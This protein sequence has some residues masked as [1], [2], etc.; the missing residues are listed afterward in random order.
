MN[1]SVII[2]V[3]NGIS[4]LP[5]CLRT[6]LAQEGLV[7]EI[8]AV[9]NASSDGSAA[10]IAQN[11]PSVRLICNQENVGFGAA[12][13]MGLDCATGE[14]LVLLNQDTE[15]RPDWLRALTNVFRDD[16]RIGIAGSK[17]VYADGLIQHAGGKVDEQGNGSHIGHRNEDNG[18][19]E[20]RLDVDYVTGA[21]LAISRQA[22]VT[23][24][25]FDEKFGLSYYEDVDLCYRVRCAN[26]RVVYEPRSVLVH[27]ERSVSAD[28]TIEGN[29]RTQQN[30]LRFVLKNWPTEQLINE[31]VPHEEA[32][33]KELIPNS[34]IVV[35]AL[36]RAY[37]RTMI[38]SAEL[39]TYRQRHFTDAVDVSQI[40]R[41][42]WLNLEL[43][44]ELRKIG[45]NQSHSGESPILN[46]ATHYSDLAISSHIEDIWQQHPLRSQPFHSDVPLIGPLIAGFRQ[47]WN[48]VS[49]EWFV[50]P[51]MHQ[52]NQ[53]N[54][55]MIRTL[56]QIVS[57]RTQTIHLQA[58]HITELAQQL[59]VL[60]KKVGLLREQIITI[61]KQNDSEQN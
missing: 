7:F 8:I 48:R 52:Q 54:E 1:A 20:Q 16:E 41:S 13:N 47:C 6:L 28:G 30:R 31:F 11:F 49:A 18:Q 26:Y 37:L 34:L 40:V 39:S 45:Y 50:R 46:P 2:P 22:Y 4:D 51:I 43:N 10:Y 23:C 44:E 59:G 42:L 38:M 33:I 60:E 24:G 36:R 53:I 5:A 9:D 32:R 14:L 61:Q 15:V 56:E 55:Q 25:G 21:S 29:A 35:N 57:D 3:W 27:N 58:A 17:A 19:Y 12:C